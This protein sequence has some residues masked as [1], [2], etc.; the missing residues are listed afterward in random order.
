MPREGPRPLRGKNQPLIAA[1]RQHVGLQL[2][3]VATVIARL[4][5][6][7]HD[8]RD[9]GAKARVQPHAPIIIHEHSRVKR[10]PITSASPI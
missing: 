9:M 7:R 5:A 4:D 6:A 8:G 10:H 3:K 1:H 2:H